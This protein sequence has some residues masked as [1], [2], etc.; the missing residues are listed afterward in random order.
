M[1]RAAVL[2]VFDN[3]RRREHIL[4]TDADKNVQRQS[5]NHAAREVAFCVGA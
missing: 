3:P 1:D 2:Y 4:L 5:G